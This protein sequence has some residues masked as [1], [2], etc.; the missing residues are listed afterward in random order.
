MR[1]NKI[2]VLFFLVFLNLLPASAQQWAENISKPYTVSKGLN[3]KHIALWASHGLYYDQK[4]GYWRYQRPNLYNTTE[5]LF[6]QTIVVPYLMPMLENAGAYVFSPRERDWQKREYVD[7][8][9]EVPGRYAV[10]IKY[11]YNKNASE[12]ALYTVVH[13]G[14]RTDFSVNKRIGWGTWVYL[15]TFDFG[16]DPNLNYVTAEHYRFGGGMGSIVRGGHTSGV[17]RCI[18]GARYYAEYAGAPE[19]VWKNKDGEDDYAE[20]INTR[21]LFVNWLMDEGVPF[22]LSLAVHSDAGIHED[23]GIYGSMA[24]ATT[25]LGNP[26]RNGLSRDW[27]LDLASQLLHNLETDMK[28]EFGTW[29]IRTVKDKNYSETRL[30]EVPSAIIETLSHQNFTDMKYGQDPRGKFT[31]ARSLYKTVG[32]WLA[33]RAGREFIVQPLAPQ[34]FRLSLNDDML[35]LEWD[36]TEDRTEPTAKPTHYII[37]TSAG[38]GGGFDNGQKVNTTSANMR[39]PRGVQ[40]SFMITAVHEGGESFSTEVLSAYV[41]PKSASS[42]A[43]SASSPAPTVLV[44]SAFERLSTPYIVQND[45]VQK[46]DFELD[47]GVQRGLYAGWD[48]GW[49]M[50]NSFDYAV[51]HVRAIASTGHYSAVSCS[52]SAVVQNKV[53]LAPY[54]VVDFAFGLQRDRFHTLSHNLRRQIDWFMSKGGAVFISGAFLGSDNQTIDEREWLTN[55]LKLEWHNMDSDPTN[56]VQGLGLGFNYYHSLNEEHYAALHPECLSATDDGFCA[57]LYGNGAS[58]AVA[59]RRCFTMGFPFECIISEETKDKLMQGIINYLAQ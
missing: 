45:S 57:M 22:D 8:P 10:Y 1:V 56:Y 15:G 58:A 27:S 12:E 38:A 42:P 29:T 19:W 28:N 36:A 30:P 41:C 43:N 9:I 20:D 34:N 11:D 24:I 17:P 32:R 21:S 33:A 39:L 52:L 16:S 55:T 47:E 54:T 18:E 14:I 48:K 13:K 59:G 4:K 35:L 3:N 25:E 31:I 51:D 46:F 6:T 40:F 23:Q 7:K 44:V 50:G 49:H 26:L 53:D 2:L 37:Y 5:D